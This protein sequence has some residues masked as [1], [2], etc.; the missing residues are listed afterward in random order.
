MLETKWNAWC[1]LFSSL[2]VFVIASFFHELLFIMCLM[3]C[4]VFLELLRTI[5]KHRETPLTYPNTSWDTL[6]TIQQQIQKWRTSVSLEWSGSELFCTILFCSKGNCWTDWN[7]P[8][9][10]P[11]FLMLS[12][13]LRDISGRLH[14]WE[15]F[16]RFGGSVWEDY[17][18]LFC[19]V[20][21]WH[22]R[23]ML[24][25]FLGLFLDSCQLVFGTS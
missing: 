24:V 20:F 14:V 2:E 21:F 11:W 23:D 5:E 25:I 16:E 3:K 8:Y 18:K 7:Q 4:I 6:R 1:V 10:F 12:Y 19:I 9:C 22:L 13:H 17:G 15:V